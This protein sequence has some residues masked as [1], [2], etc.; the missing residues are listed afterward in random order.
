MRI[1]KPA[2]ELRVVAS[3]ELR[4]GAL[5]E[6]LL[7]LV[8][9]AAAAAVVT[10]ALS[11]SVASLERQKFS[12]QALNLAATTVA[13]VQLGIRPANSDG[14]RPMEPPFQDWTWETV[15]TP[16][17]TAGGTSASSMRLDVIVRHQT[18]S[19][20]QRL[21]QVVRLNSDTS[22][23]SLPSTAD[24]RAR[25]SGAGTA[26]SPVLVKRP[27]AHEDEAIPAPF[28]NPPRPVSLSRL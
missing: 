21:A 7:A 11:A 4:A 2:N 8:L 9:F 17:E 20:V 16:M 13:E 22:T 19:V 27:T 25:G 18:S 24:S 28:L 3:K 26:S 23:N 5:L 15:L 1:S 10:S 14:P 12:S 6:V